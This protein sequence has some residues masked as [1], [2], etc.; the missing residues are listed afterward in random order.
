MLHSL[1][2]TL[3]NYPGVL[4]IQTKSP[5]SLY[6]SPNLPDMDVFFQAFLAHMF[7]IFEEIFLCL[8]G[9][10]GGVH[11]IVFLGR[12]LYSHSAS[13]PE[14]WPLENFMLVVALQC[15]IISSIPLLHV[16]EKYM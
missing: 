14:H 2:P 9:V 7:A 6:R 13:P 16:T 11:C 12:T 1:M 8:M 15:T 5:S 10:P 4:W 3:Q